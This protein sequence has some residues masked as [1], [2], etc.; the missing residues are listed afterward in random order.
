V[1]L[2]FIFRAVYTGIK[3]IV[4][5]LSL[6]PVFFWLP[7]YFVIFMSIVQDLEQ[8]PD[9]RSSGFST[10]FSW[11]LLGKFF[12]YPQNFKDKTQRK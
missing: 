1:Y 4:R 9:Y 11:W 6:T 12:M 3:K 2:W 8:K 5:I 7:G 10:V